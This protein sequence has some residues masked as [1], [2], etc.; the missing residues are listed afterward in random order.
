MSLPGNGGGGARATRP[1]KFMPF[2]FG[3]WP[4]PPGIFVQGDGPIGGTVPW[5]RDWLIRFQIPKYFL[6]NGLSSKGLKA[7]LE[8]NNMVKMNKNVKKLTFALWNSIWLDELEIEV[9][10]KIF[11]PFQLMRVLVEIWYVHTRTYIGF[12]VWY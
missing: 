4:P 3:Q 9:I 8:V 7:A 2:K 6:I 1:A 12:R 11:F 5:A 10:N